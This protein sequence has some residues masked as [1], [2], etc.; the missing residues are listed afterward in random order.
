M[1]TLYSTTS[2]TDV[3][4]KLKLVEMCPAAIAAAYMAGFG[5]ENIRKAASLSF[6]YSRRQRSKFPGVFGDERCIIIGNEQIVQ[7]L[8]NQL[9]GESIWNA[10]R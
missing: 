1:L 3:C 8:R 7:G 4:G 5:L 9:Q 2:A 6:V 10:A